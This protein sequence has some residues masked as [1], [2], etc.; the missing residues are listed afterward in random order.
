MFDVI[1]RLRIRA[2]LL[3]GFLLITLIP[4][5]IV[6]II[7]YALLKDSVETNSVRLISDILEQI[8]KSIAKEI[9]DLDNMTIRAYSHPDL[10]EIIGKDEGISLFEH[11]QDVQTISHLLDEIARSKVGVLLQLFDFERRVESFTQDFALFSSLESFILI[12]WNGLKNDPLFLA[13]METKG[14]KS[15][16]GHLQ[17]SSWQNYDKFLVMIR[18]VKEGK[19]I[20]GAIPAQNQIRFGKEIKGAVVVCIKETDLANIYTTSYLAQMGHIYLLDP[21]GEVFSSSDERAAVPPFQSPIPAQRFA[22]I[23]ARKQSYA[24]IDYQAEKYLLSFTN[25]PRIG[26][27]LYTLQPEHAVMAN[28]YVLRDTLFIITG[29]SVCLA[30]VVSLFISTSLTKPIGVF[31]STIQHIKQTG[32]VFN[33]QTINQTIRERLAQD[34]RSKDEI[35]AMAEAFGNM[36]GA[37]E[38][39]QQNLLGQERLKQEMELARNIQMSLLPKDLKHQELEIEAVMLPAEE[40]GGDY[41]DML[42]DRN[43]RLWLGIGDV[44][45]HGMTPGLIMMMAQTIHTTITTQWEV[46]PKQVV[47]ILNQVLYHN[48]TGRLNADHFMTFTTLKYLGNGRFR[49]AGSHLDLIVFRHAAQTCELIDTPGVWLLFMPDIEDATDEMELT[50]EIGDLLVLYSDGLSEAENSEK[51]LFGMERLMNSVTAHHTLPTVALR[52]AVM[53]DVLAWCGDQRDDDMTLMVVRRVA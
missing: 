24:W 10:L 1:R 45:G 42:F 16:F 39:A 31:T 53:A 21:D 22:D 12:D 37:L 36:L 15:A 44:S 34:I 32:Y 25:I 33:D 3:S 13:A 18:G 30:I 6:T 9:N 50:L 35:G 4:I 11:D 19:V 46:S 40:V 8:S 5:V 41:Y 23:E 52:D 48:V 38:A 29:V 26:L 43:G 20:H 2:K 51:I 49:H 14:R 17:A 27:I 47:T 7:V 28:F